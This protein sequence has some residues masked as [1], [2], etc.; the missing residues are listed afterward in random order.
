[1]E[2]LREVGQKAIDSINKL[3]ASDAG[4]LVLGI[5]EIIQ[6]LREQPELYQEKL[7]HLEGL[8]REFAYG[9]GYE[10]RNNRVEILEEGDTLS[11]SFGIGGAMSGLMMT[12]PN[13]SGAF[14]PNTFSSVAGI[15]P[16]MPTVTPS[17][18]QDDTILDEEEEVEDELVP[19]PVI[20]EPKKFKKRWWKTKLKPK[21]K[22]MDRNECDWNEEFK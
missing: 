17:W 7:D 4:D 15:P 16:V 10:L 5:G 11:Q 14:P 1:M 3:R 12:F 8:F 21:E 20:P 19:A 6:E 18:D 22:F 2:D 13:V 9:E